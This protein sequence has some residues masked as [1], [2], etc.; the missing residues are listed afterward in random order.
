[1]GRWGGPRLL[2][3]FK[4]VYLVVMVPLYFFCMIMSGLFQSD[5]ECWIRLIAN[6]YSAESHPLV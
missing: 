5:V 6:D 1:M 2:T 3:L 4:L